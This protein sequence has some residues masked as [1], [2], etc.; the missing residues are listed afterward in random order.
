ML[1][2]VELP[3][4]ILEVMFWAPELAEAASRVSASRRPPGR[5]CRP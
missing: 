2:R 5:V 3:E 4:V 1:P